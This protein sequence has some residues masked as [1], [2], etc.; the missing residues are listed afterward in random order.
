MKVVLVTFRKGARRDLPLQAEKTTIG[1]GVDCALR[2]PLKDVSRK[3]CEIVI[4][5]QHVNVRDLK[6]SNGTFV[7]G[8]RTEDARLKP[9][10]QIMVGSVIFV[11]QI[12][13]RPATIKPEDVVASTDDSVLDLPAL[14]D[15]GETG[16]VLEL[17]DF[18]VEDDPPA[19]GG[20]S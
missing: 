16:G 12:D 14:D 17:D 10:D 1:R 8:K 20:K 15:D 4:G 6:S 3:H 18:D 13:G 9:G 7:N 19:T 11:V 5:R 2:I